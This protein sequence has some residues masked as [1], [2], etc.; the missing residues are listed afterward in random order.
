V[1]RVEEAYFPHPESMDYGVILRGDIPL[2]KFAPVL[3]K[4]PT[5][6]LAKISKSFSI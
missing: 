6:V 3:S 4:L 5:K 2:S 1:V